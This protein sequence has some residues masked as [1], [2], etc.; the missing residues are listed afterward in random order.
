MRAWI[1][2]VALDP[3]D[4]VPLFVQ[5]ERAITHDVRRGRLR[6][7][8]LLPGT[9]TLA[10]TLGVHR[11]TVVAAYEE[12]IAQGWVATRP[13]G[14]TVVAASPPE[15]RPRRLKGAR[16]GVALPARAGFD[17]APL[18]APATTAPGPN[19]LALWGG[20]PDLRLVPAA[21]LGRAWRRAVRSGR[22]LLGYAPDGRG[23]PR[24][25]SALAGLMSATRGLA[26]TADDLLVV[27]GSQM[28]L[29]LV[30]RSLI[31]PGDVAAVEAPGY[32]P[33]RLA[34]ARAGARVVPIP[35]DREGFRVDAVEA[36][37]RSE[38]V[39]LVYVTP[40]HQYPTTVT[41][42]PSRR[43]ALLDLAARRRIA[44]VEDD[45]DHEFHFD[46]RPLLPLASGD[47]AGVVIY[48]GSLAKVLAPGLRLGY[49][50]APRAL[51][52]RMAAERALV[53][54][55]GDLVLERAV[56][57]LIED[58]ELQRH[59]R[60]LRRIYQRRRDVLCDLIAA[61]LPAL[62]AFQRPAGG[63]ALWT[64]AAPG[65]DVEAWQ[66]R[67]LRDGLMFQAGRAF[68]FQGRATPHLRLGFAIADEA[69]LARAVQILVRTAPPQRR[70]TGAG[71]ARYALRSPP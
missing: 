62:L 68:D 1:F 29:E 40:H 34:F 67:A 45:Y 2:P 53:D 6:P 61:R 10:G 65:V 55:Q 49:V 56:A 27:R 20:V 5:I 64:T 7:G 24:L 25:R 63:M 19:V 30:G 50:V 52:D 33:A 41:L 22:G 16:T 42:S 15:P 46:G 43:L 17:V 58:G 26:A 70:S 11:S 69:E 36:L 71:G 37:A 54:R 57:E 60:R 28:A 4:G 3:K 9:R 14:G 38:A 44:I 59:V 8:A 32:A 31:R 66:A 48:I 39:R 23:E 51:L 47:P 35:V 21:A 13:G 12:L 18:Q